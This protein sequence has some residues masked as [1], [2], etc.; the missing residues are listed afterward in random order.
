MQ[1]VTSNSNKR[2]IRNKNAPYLCPKCWSDD[3]VLSWSGESFTYGATHMQCIKCGY[4]LDYVLGTAYGPLNS[5]VFVDGVGCVGK[6]RL[7]KAI[8]QARVDLAELAD[9]LRKR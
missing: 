2:G 4:E 1:A 3:Q 7:N 5:G 6:Q 9:D 8:R